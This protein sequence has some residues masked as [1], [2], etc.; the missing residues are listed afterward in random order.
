MKTDVDEFASV[1]HL[2]GKHVKIIAK[3]HPWY[4]SVGHITGWA[5]TFDGTPYCE[6]T[7]TEPYDHRVAIFNGKDLKYI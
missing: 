1:R 5:R 7:L 2:E 6:V 4:E 3:D